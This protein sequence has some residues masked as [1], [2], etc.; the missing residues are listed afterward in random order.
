MSHHPTDLEML[1]DL[2]KAAGKGIMEIYATDFKV[3]IKSDDSPPHPGGHPI[4]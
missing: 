1:N 3:D 4:P 2:A